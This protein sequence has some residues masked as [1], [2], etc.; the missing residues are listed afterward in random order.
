M[1]QG[2]LFLA[3]GAGEANFLCFILPEPCRFMLSHP[4]IR[5]VG[6]AV[7]QGSHFEGFVGVVSPVLEEHR[8][9]IIFSGSFHY[10]SVEVLDF[11]RL[12]SLNEGQPKF[13][14]K[15]SFD[16]RNGTSCVEEYSDPSS[17]VFRPE[18]HHF[19]DWSW[20]ADRFWGLTP[21]GARRG[22]TRRNRSVRPSSLIS[23]FAVDILRPWSLRSANIYPWPP[24]LRS[25]GAAQKSSGSLSFLSQNGGASVIASSST[26]TAAA[27]CCLDLG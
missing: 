25:A 8:H 14:C 16:D 13:S 27:L 20:S 2:A 24:S 19:Y 11:H 23:G 7:V 4:P 18:E 21:C 26:T 3:S 12:G 1:L 5:E 22:W 6:I 10:G 15:A 17:L 9:C